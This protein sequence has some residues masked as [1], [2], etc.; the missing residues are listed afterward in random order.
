MRTNSF[1]K[2]VSA[3]ALTL[4]IANSPATSQTKNAPIEH[5]SAIKE[6][7][8]VLNSRDEIK[9]IADQ[10]PKAKSMDSAVNEL[11]GSEESTK[12]LYSISADI[13][14]VLMEMNQ[15]NPEKALESLAQY[16]KDPG[17]FLQKLPVDVRLKIEK[18]AK[19]IETSKTK[20]P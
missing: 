13:L 18:L 4:V 7:Q 19:K 1:L 11:T 10:D 12:E 16:S 15:D 6:T 2:L 17:A 8:A 20:K 9:K 5:D 14:P 3:V